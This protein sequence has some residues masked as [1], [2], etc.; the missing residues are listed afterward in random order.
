MVGSQ[1]A[2]Y[3]ILNANLFNTFYINV[4]S[5]TAFLQERFTRKELC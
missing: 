3:H 1:L 4:L 2:A 5:H